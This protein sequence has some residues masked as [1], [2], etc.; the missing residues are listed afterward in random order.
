MNQQDK[1]VLIEK[2]LDGKTTEEELLKT[3][4]REE[5]DQYKTI[6]NTVDN[7][8]PEGNEEIPN[9]LREILATQKE[10]KVVSF[11]KT[12]W[13][14]GIAASIALIATISYFFLSNTD[15][16]YYAENENL[17]IVLPDGSTTVILSPGATLSYDDFDVENREVEI[18]G[19][20]YFDVTEKGPFNVQYENGSI[21]VLG[22]QFEILHLDD[23]FEASCFEGKVKVSYQSLESEMIQGE[24]V[25]HI[26]GDLPKIQINQKKPG[27]V[28]GEEK[29]ENEDLIKVIKVIELV[30][31]VS[32]NAENISMD[33][34]FTGTIPSEDL[35]AAC[36]RVFSALG[37]NYQIQNKVII[38]SE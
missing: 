17:E 11:N 38:L 35:D 12:S 34:K 5:I 2:W 7:W 26:G 24:R 23:F 30:Y 4:P 31:N 18:D 6:L 22:T 37:I 29:F 21:S 15:T 19:R 14:V 36:K 28:D 1:E 33:R 27:W 32:I 20:V 9:R 25:T 3:I 13:I 8:I 16:V 10:A